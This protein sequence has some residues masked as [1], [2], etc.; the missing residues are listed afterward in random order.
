MI[1]S[2]GSYNYI[3]YRDMYYIYIYIYAIGGIGSCFE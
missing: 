1:N 2:I 3:R